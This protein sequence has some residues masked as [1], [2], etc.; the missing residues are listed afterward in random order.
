MRNALLLTMDPD[1]PDPD[2]LLD[3]VRADEARADQGRLKIFF[4]MAPGVGKTYAMLEA[5][6]ELA[7]DGVDVV[8]G[9]LEP[10]VRPETQAL[11]LGLDMLARRSVNHHGRAVFEF[12]VDA[13]NVF[14]NVYFTT[15]SGV[16]SSTADGFEVTGATSGR[17]IQ[18]V[19]RISW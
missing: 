13:L 16:G 15:V 11:A 14:D 7:K 5:A 8:V 9:Y 12:R 19:S 3:R 1:R 17:T 4:G 18:L 2:T 10:H 6:R